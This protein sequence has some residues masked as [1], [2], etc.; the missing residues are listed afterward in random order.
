MQSGGVEAMVSTLCNEMVK[1][2]DVSFCSIFEFKGTEVFLKIMDKKV[3]I[4]TLHKS[5]PGFQLSILWKIY[6]F[7]KEQKFE[8]VNIHGF[9]YYYFIAVILLHSKCR[10]FYTVHS[11]AKKENTK[12]DKR[13]FFLKRYCF[14]K[15][16]M[17]PITISKESKRS[18]DKLY[19]IESHQIYNGTPKINVEKKDLSKYKITSNTR[20]IF[21]PAR[22]SEAKNQKMLCRVCQR[23]IDEG[24]D[25]V[26]IIAGSNQDNNIFTEISK[27]FSD[28]I[29][30]LGERSDVRNIMS[31]A[32]AFVL[33]SL[34]E[35]MPVS[36]LEALSIGCIPICTPVGG[37]PEVVR[38]E[39][40]GFIS[41]TNNED[42]FYRTLKAYCSM[43]SENLC[44]IKVNV[45]KEFTKFNIKNTALEYEKY[46]QF[47]D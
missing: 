43:S 13:L 23:L 42:D 11:D 26:L 21:N 41:R 7:I 9:F 31:S 46:Y 3:N 20:I 38:N 30:Y 22:I 37:I 29:V 16:W 28:R 39:F 35:G 5:S 2:H 8:V 15:G 44:Q 17:K 1:R 4:F 40:T 47:V 33:S 25:I 32:D 45:E 10:F 18:F 24:S 6:K 36:L 19:D 12:W 34:W 14:R 27:Y